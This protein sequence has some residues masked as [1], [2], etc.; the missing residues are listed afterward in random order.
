PELDPVGTSFRRW[1]ELLAAD[2][3]GEHR[4]AELQDWL[5]FLGDDVKPLAR[6]ALDP[7]VDTARTLRRSSWVVPS[8]QAQAL[9]GRV[10]V[11]FHCG[12]DDVLLAAL[13]GAVAHGRREAISGLLIDV[14]GHGREPLGADGGVDLSRTVGWFTS[15]HP[16]RTNAS[17]IDLAQVLDGGPAAGALLKAVKEQLRAVPGGDGLGYEL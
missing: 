10:P 15:A 8:E 4:V 7:A 12:V 9:L 16:V 6:R 5:A 14:E 13:T 2:A 1:A 11:A 3:T 17:G